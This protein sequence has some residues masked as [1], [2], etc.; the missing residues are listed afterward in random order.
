[1]GIDSYC[2]G[3]CERCALTAYCRLFADAAETDAS[4]DPGLRAVVDA[5]PLP[6]DVPPPPPRC[7]QELID[8][9]HQRFVADLV[10]L[11]EAVEEVFPAARGFVRSGLDD[12]RR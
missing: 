6:D 8:E 2:D 3:W 4:R 7:L 5:P 10:W 11:G 12:P 1:M 9:C